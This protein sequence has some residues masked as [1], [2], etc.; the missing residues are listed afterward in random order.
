MQSHPGRTRTLKRHRH[1]CSSPYGCRRE[2]IELRL[3]CATAHLPSCLTYPSSSKQTLEQNK[4][5]EPRWLLSSN[6]SFTRGPSWLHSTC[7]TW[8]ISVDRGSSL[9]ELV[10]KK[11]FGWTFIT[12]VTGGLALAWA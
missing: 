4:S 6:C 5:F 1:K 12:L 11:F 9:Y 8:V 2:L 7:G 3:I 10:L